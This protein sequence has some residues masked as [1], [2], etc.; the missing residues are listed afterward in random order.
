MALIESGK[1]LDKNEQHSRLKKRMDNMDV[2]Q[3]PLRIPNHLYKK[4]KLKMVHEDVK[5]T[6][7]LLGMLE[8][9]VK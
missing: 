4:V 3:F 7:L 8:D 9:Y 1:T 5:L 2:T 6:H